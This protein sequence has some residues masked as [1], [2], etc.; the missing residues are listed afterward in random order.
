MTNRTAQRFYR[1]LVRIIRCNEENRVPDSS[2]VQESLMLIRW[3]MKNDQI[4]VHH[5][6]SGFMSYDFCSGCGTIVSSGDCYCSSCGREL[7]WP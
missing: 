4:R 7:I 5:N 2:M 6:V 3:L 1:L